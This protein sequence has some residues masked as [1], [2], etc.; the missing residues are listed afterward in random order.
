M[1][2]DANTT[3]LNDNNAPII[4]GYEGPV[5]AARALYESA[6][7]DYAMF[8]AM[9]NIDAKE[10]SITSKNSIMAESQIESLCEAAGNGLWSKISQLWQTITEKL[11]SIIRSFCIK[12]MKLFADGKKL[13][14]KYE[15]LI[16]VNAA[17]E[18]KV[19]WNRY[20]S[21]N[22]EDSIIDNLAS[23]RKLVIPDDVDGLKADYDKIVRDK[24]INSDDGIWENVFK[25]EKVS[26][27]KDYETALR[28]KYGLNGGD[29]EV[30]IDDLGGIVNICNTLRTYDKRIEG[31]RKNYNETIKKAKSL[32]KSAKK[33][34]G[35]VRKNTSK[36]EVTLIDKEG[37]ATG[38]VNGKKKAVSEATEV[39]QFSCFW[40]DA[41]MVES[42]VYINLLTRD[43]KQ[44]KSALIKAYGS[45]GPYKESAIY[46]DALAEAAEDEVDNVISGVI[47]SDAGSQ[48]TD[49][50]LAATDV[51]DDD[52]SD[53]PDALT[54][55]KTNCYSY[56]A[57]TDE[58]DGSIDTTI[59]SNESAYFGALLY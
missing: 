41:L 26:N 38:K 13:A 59:N 31:F 35:E 33:Y 50:C 54:Y 8:E 18:V 16:D 56:N 3:D 15:K 25:T 39:Y 49:L 22:A 30:T 51:K 44:H 11:A 46:F 42:R 36:D 55:D 5:G 6:K 10:M 17:N 34:I 20:I 47:D 12:F 48:I 14:D 24:D 23:Q 28:E 43:F 32:S 57:P 58:P 2:F 7:Y 21:S 29:V 37:N 1:I 19:K 52:V 45:V 53:D 9:L 40:R 4:E 27:A